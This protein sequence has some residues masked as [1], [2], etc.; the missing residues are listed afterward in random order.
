MPLTVQPVTPRDVAHLH[1]WKWPNPPDAIYALWHQTR[2]VSVVHLFDLE[3]VPLGGGSP[4][5]VCGMGGIATEPLERGKG[6]AEL[7][8]SR[9]MTEHTQ[10]PDGVEG[11]LLNGRAEAGLWSR[12]G[13]QD[14]GESLTAPPQRLWWAGCKRFL[15]RPEAEL[16]GQFRIEP[17]DHW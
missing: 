5:P 16:P 14:V 12:L 4:F 10:V 8:L 15:E 3:V 11:F 6:R 13:F 9:V 2:F 1:K 17:G 7:L